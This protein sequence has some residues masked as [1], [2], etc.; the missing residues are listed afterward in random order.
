MYE[1]KTRR[2]TGRMCPNRRRT[3]HPFIL[4]FFLPIAMHVFYRS[5]SW[6]ASGNLLSRSLAV[7]SSKVWRSSRSRHRGSTSTWRPAE[8]DKYPPFLQQ[9]T[10]A[11]P[12]TK[13]AAWGFGLP[14]DV[15]TRKKERTPKD[16]ERTILVYVREVLAAATTAGCC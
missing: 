13:L 9:P 2:G 5:L 11:L 1:A 7:S 12:K 14:R 6:V 4:S 8:T 10:H 16:T 15:E 3:C